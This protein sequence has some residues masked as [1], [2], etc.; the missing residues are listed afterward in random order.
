MAPNAG[1][2]R[3]AQSDQ[4]DP[5]QLDPRLITE[6]DGTTDVVE[7]L[8]RA[9]LICS[10]RGVDVMDVIPLRLTGGAFAVWS[11]LPS[12]DRTSLTI[13]K[14][15]LHA[16]F[17][18]DENAAYDAFVLRRLRH[19][20]SAD[21]FLAD[22]RRLAALFGGVPERTLKCAFI[23]GLPD[24]VRRTIRAGSKAENLEL[25]DVLTRARAVL[26]DERIALAATSERTHLKTSRQR[27]QSIRE[28]ARLEP[29]PARQPRLC[30]VCGEPSHLA[31][32]C[33][34]RAGNATGDGASAPASS[35]A[36]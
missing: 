16:A 15:A 23:A 1:R 34:R 12:E 35:P 9:E 18:L 14:A 27:Q 17:A 24:S 5:G 25:T 3:K 30:W 33:P 28:A 4:A 10:H 20:E 29:H 32:R 13:V 2:K 11:Q 7:W 19:G 6:F 22:L 8:S 31:A 21:V 26:G 36:Q